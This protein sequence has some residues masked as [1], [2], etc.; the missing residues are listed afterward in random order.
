MAPMRFVAFAAM[1]VGCTLI[2][3]NGDPASAHQPTKSAHSPHLASCSPSDLTA[4][5]ELTPVGKSPSAL[6]G[7]IV[8]ANHSHSACTLGGVPKVTAVNP[9]GQVI[10]VFQVPN[11]IRHS[12]AVMLPASPTSARLPDTGVSI[13]WSDWNCAKNSFALVVKF[14]GWK[15]ALTAPWGVTAGYAGASCVSGQASLY[16]GPV[17]RIAAP[18]V[19][20]PSVAAP[21]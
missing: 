3:S 12:R 19:A 9:A 15:E 11:L 21:S 6:A 18:S 16:I 2:V 10:D 7:A 13:T 20:A 5:A 14:A 4:T 1:S 8:F 17:A